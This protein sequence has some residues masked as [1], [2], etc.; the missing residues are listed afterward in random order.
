M[1]EI[2]SRDVS[3]AKSHP[4]PPTTPLAGYELAD[5]NRFSDLPVNPLLQGNDTHASNARIGDELLRRSAARSIQEVVM[6][7]AERQGYIRPAKKARNLAAKKKSN[8]RP[9]PPPKLIYWLIMRS[10]L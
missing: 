5:I 8:Q 10:K 1:G 9:A 3:D 2:G 4:S 7:K 6:A